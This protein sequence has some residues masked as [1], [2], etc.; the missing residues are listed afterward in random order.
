M[1]TAAVPDLPLSWTLTACTVTVDGEGT[2]GGAMYA[3]FAEIVPTVASPPG[4]LL[5]IQVT[6]ELKEPVPWTGAV[7]CWEV[8]TIGP[9]VLG[10]MVTE[11]IVGVG[12]GGALKS[13]RH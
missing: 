1:V 13:F 7:N 2:L 11:V 6:A 9:D 8:P 5:T 4:M 3:P 12:G 10:E